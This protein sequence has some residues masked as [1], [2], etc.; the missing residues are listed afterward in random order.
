MQKR[1]R[2]NA[3]DV[4]LPPKWYTTR[5]EP[6]S[7]HGTKKGLTVVL[8]AHSNLVSPASVT[9]DFDGFLSI[10]APKDGYP[11]TEENQIYLKPGWCKERYSYHCTKLS[12]HL[13]Y[14]S[15]YG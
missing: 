12:S 9:E 11:L 8:D 5:K 15:L 2:K 7:Q 13:L 14:P 3:F 6:K 1:D 10:V 4:T